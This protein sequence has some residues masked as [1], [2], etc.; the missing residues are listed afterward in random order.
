MILQLY[1]IKLKDDIP[2]LLKLRILTFRMRIL[3]HHPWLQQ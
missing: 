2:T 3:I 1:D